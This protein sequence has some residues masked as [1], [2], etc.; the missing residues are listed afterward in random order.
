M[1]YGMETKTLVRLPPLGAS[2]VPSVRRAPTQSC[3]TMQT[4]TAGLRNPGRE[5]ATSK[6]YPGYP[7]EFYP[8]PPA[9]RATPPDT[10]LYVEVKP[11]QEPIVFHPQYD[12]RFFGLENLH[13]F[14]AKK[15]GKVKQ[16]LVSRRLIREE[17]IVSPEAAS[18]ED[19]EVVHTREY[20]KSLKSSFLVAA[21]TEVLPVAVLPNS[22]VQSRLIDPFRRHTGGSV[23]AGKLALERGW[24]INIGGGFHHCCGCAGG[25][26]CVFA[27]ITLCAY[28]ARDKKKIRRIMIVDLDAHQGNGHERDL[29]GDK[30]V[31]IL[32]VY[33]SEVYPQDNAAK[34]AIDKKVELKCGTSTEVYLKAVQGALN[35]AAQEL[36]S[37]PPELIIYN[38][39]TDV[40]EGDRLGRLNVSPEGVIARDEMVFAFAKSRSIPIVMLTSGGYQK[41]TAGVIADSIANLAQQ[42]LITLGTKQVSVSE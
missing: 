2:A 9:R 38:A 3:R 17:Q 39:G 42:G 35:E 12:I 40:L 14:D 4:P 15:W 5:M 18:D 6:S 26:F 1:L 29:M 10:L 37:A 19:L 32:D 20:L 33:N 7:G 27:D 28:F 13:S 11:E 8:G 36:A 22:L 31:Y 41:S 16:N 25:G 24:A 21:I 23:L 30:D 34:A